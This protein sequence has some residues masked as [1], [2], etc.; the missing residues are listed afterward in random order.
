[1]ES[2]LRSFL[3]ETSSKEWCDD[4]CQPNYEF[5]LVLNL[6]ST[7]F[8]MSRQLCNSQ[9]DRFCFICAKYCFLKQLRPINDNVREEYDSCFK[10]PLCDQEPHK[11]WA[12]K[13]ICTTCLNSLSKWKRKL[14]N[15]FKFSTPAQWCEPRDHVN[16][17]YFCLIN[18][19]GYSA[20]NRHLIVYPTSTS[21]TRPIA[22]DERYQLPTPQLEDETSIWNED[23]EMASEEDDEMR[24]DL[25]PVF[26]L[27]ACDEKVKWS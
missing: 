15:S 23:S 6:L 16:D 14:S 27:P 13:Y 2:A 8:I 17:C 26:K 4:T 19:K 5:S 25:D 3:W 24:S 21:V 18:P 22:P 11:W 12:P 7:T 10:Q 1:M 20:T 9:P